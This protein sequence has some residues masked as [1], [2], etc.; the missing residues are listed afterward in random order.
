MFIVFLKFSANKGRAGELMADHNEWIARG[1]ADGVF[2][3]VGALQPRLGGA[4]IAHNTTRDEL[5]ARL[6]ADPFVAHDVVAVELF[7][8]S[9]SKS[10]LRL[11][12]LLV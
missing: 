12:F 7:D 3:L 6:Q 11:A 10:D 9:P 5:A 4:I 2:L 1:L 8:V